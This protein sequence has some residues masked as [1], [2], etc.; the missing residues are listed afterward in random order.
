MRGKIAKLVGST[1]TL[2]AVGSI[3]I[4]GLRAQ[5]TADSSITSPATTNWVGYLVVGEYVGTGQSGPIDPMPGTTG[6]HPATV[7]HVQI[8]LRSDGVVIWR[9]AKLK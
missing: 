4:I 5:Q 7:R 1:I 2:L 9:T 3:G 6:P 8:G